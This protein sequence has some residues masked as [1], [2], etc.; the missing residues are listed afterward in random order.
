MAVS[1]RGTSLVV[2]TAH[3]PPTPPGLLRVLFLTVARIWAVGAHLASGPSESAGS[4]QWAG[5]VY[6]KSEMGGEEH[7]SGQPRQARDP[8]S[9]LGP[10]ALADGN[11]RPVKVEGGNGDTADCVRKRP[12]HTCRV[13]P[14]GATARRWGWKTDDTSW[15]GADCHR[16]CQHMPLPSAHCPCSW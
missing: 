12:G 14:G 10:P 15:S 3:P 9:L 7:D 16:D 11:R 1:W 13:T 2:R 8:P 6:G 5:V 4:V